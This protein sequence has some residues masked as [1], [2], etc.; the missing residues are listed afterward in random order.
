[1]HLKEQYTYTFDDNK[2]SLLV[3]GRLVVQQPFDSDTGSKFVNID[4]ALAWAIR[5]FPDYFTP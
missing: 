1:M 3:H 5:Y 2:L 4:Q